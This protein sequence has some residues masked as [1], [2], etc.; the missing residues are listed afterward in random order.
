M[1]GAS[2]FQ[3][4]TNWPEIEIFT[5]SI[6]TI[7]HGVKKHL[8]SDIKI[9][10][11]RKTSVSLFSKLPSEYHS[12][13]NVFLVSESDKLLPYWNYDHAINLEPGTKPN[14]RSL[15]GMSRD[16]FLVLKKYIE[17]NLCKRSIQ[18]STSSTISP[19]LFT[20][21]LGGGLCFCINYRKLNAITMK[22]YYPILL[23]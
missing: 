1:I 19:V 15:Y 11:K 22:N 3:F 18:A 12:Y 23:I 7:N 9:A 13:A 14:H 5:P 21:K 2:A 20:R 4:L 16:K 17:D 8:D 6:N 10:L